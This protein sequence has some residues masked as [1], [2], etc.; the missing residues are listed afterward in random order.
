ML[1]LSED[2]ACIV[3]R[4]AEA[5]DSLFDKGGEGIRRVMRANGA[6]KDILNVAP[7]PM[8]SQDDA[9]S[10]LLATSLLLRELARD[11]LKQVERDVALAPGSLNGLLTPTP[12]PND[13]DDASFL[14]AMRYTP[15][16]SS[17]PTT[18]AHTAGG[19]EEHVDRGLLTLITGTSSAA[20]EVWDRVE[21]AWVTPPSGSGVVV[22][23]VGATLHRATAG[24]VPRASEEGDVG[25]VR[26]RVLAGADARRSLVFRLRAQPAEHFNCVALRGRDGAVERFVDGTE[27]IETFLVSQNFTSVNADSAESAAPYGNAHASS[28]LDDG[29]FEALAERCFD[30]AGAACTDSGAMRASTFDTLTDD[31]ARQGLSGPARCRALLVGLQLCHLLLAATKTTTRECSHAASDDER[32]LVRRVAQ[33]PEVAA[34]C[35]LLVH[36]LRAKLDGRATPPPPAPATNPPASITATSQSMPPPFVFG[37]AQPSSVAPTFVFGSPAS[38]PA[39]FAFSASVLDSSIFAFTAAPAV[40]ATQRAGGDLRAAPVADDAEEDD[41]DEEED[42][43]EEEDDEDYSDDDDEEDDYDLSE[44]EDLND[45]D[46]ASDVDSWALDEQA[47]L[48]ERDA[49][50]EWADRLTRRWRVHAPLPSFDRRPYKWL[51][52]PLSVMQVI[53]MKTRRLA[54]PYIDA[55]LLGHTHGIP[56]C[57]WLVAARL[58][59]AAWALRLER[60]LATLKAAVRPHIERAYEI[61]RRQH[62][63]PLRQG[64]ALTSCFGLDTGRL[65][66]ECA[67]AMV[68]QHVV[69]LAQPIWRSGRLSRIN[70]KVVTQDGDEVFFTCKMSTPLEMLMKAFCNRYGVAAN[71]VR[72]LF[73][74][75]RINGSQTPR[76]LDMEDGD[77]IDVMVEQ[78]GD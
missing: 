27:S 19:G 44:I 23:L 4:G 46:G 14:S 30:E 42:E 11:V 72:F 49:Y 40:S 26:H 70:L 43:E 2:N 39:A 37:A 76:E 59:C 16:P 75:N 69:R 77:V 63:T 17:A 51:P 71:S 32:E 66:Q 10:T 6:V 53:K 55:R 56:G 64:P 58:I 52:L 41:D 18:D 31:V 48:F 12:D 7:D 50:V 21:H 8:K 73:D 22:L 3:Q 24:L 78:Q 68:L 36:V 29:T 62:A 25:A 15:A 45:I 34:W 20:L 38:T 5:A 28:L 1:T 65:L 61:H 13:E 35:A 67:A 47:I 33:A 74:G 9:T 60:R 57:K 54:A